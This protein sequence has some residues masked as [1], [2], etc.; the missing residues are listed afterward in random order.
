MLHQPKKTGAPRPFQQGMSYNPPQYFGGYN[1]QIPSQPWYQPNQPP[2]T[3]KNQ[4]QY[5]ANMFLLLINHFKT[6][7]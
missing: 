4:W 5:Q 1:T 3:M 2:W 7:L 6:N